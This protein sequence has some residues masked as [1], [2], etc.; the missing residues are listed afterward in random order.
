MTTTTKTVTPVDEMEQPP[1]KCPRC[2][3]MNAPLC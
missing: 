1:E 2:K 3:N